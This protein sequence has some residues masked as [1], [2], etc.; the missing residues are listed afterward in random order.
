MTGYFSNILHTARKT[1]CQIV[2]AALRV[3]VVCL[4][5]M[6]GLAVQAQVD[7]EMVTI[8][9]RNALSVDDYLTA[10]R[11]FNQ[12]IEAKPFLSRPYYY[13]AYANNN[14]R[15]YTLAKNDYETLIRLA[16]RN[17]EAR[18]GLIY[19]LTCLKKH[20]DALDQANIL[21]ELFPDSSEAFAARA[22]VEEDMNAFE[23]ALYD[24]DQAIRLSPTES[25]YIIAKAEI[26]IHLNRKQE[27]K[28][29]LQAA[30]KRGIPRESLL[31]IMARC[32]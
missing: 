32:R 29:L 22:G 20:N 19:T 24:L 26:L 21:I 1:G 11:Y 6:R 7:A 3:V 17:K 25:E 12:A 23:L 9:G 2:A 10:I 5:C 30:L 16:P 8:M 18:L 15:R 28:T 14:L 31:A 4:L 27:A 13:R